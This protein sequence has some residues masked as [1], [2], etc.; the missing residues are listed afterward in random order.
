[1][2]WSLW[3][4]IS[5]CV[6][7]LQI[8]NRKYQAWILK[9]VFVKTFINSILK[10]KKSLPYYSIKQ[11]ASLNSLGEGECVECTSLASC[12]NAEV[13]VWPTTHPRVE[14]SL[15]IFLYS[16]FSVVFVQL[17]SYFTCRTFV[18]KKKS[19]ELVLI[20]Q[21]SDR[22]MLKICANWYSHPPS[23]FPVTSFLRQ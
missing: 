5:F 18:L 19:N 13:D 6:A 2:N 15:L 8:L 21:L 14:I 4:F 1:M 16:H 10:S 3:N 23:L 17:F 7:L 9:F 11:V 20:Q 12:H 22:K